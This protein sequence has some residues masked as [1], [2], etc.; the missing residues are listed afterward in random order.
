[1]KNHLTLFLTMVCLLAVALG[2]EFSATTANL[3]DI[4]LAKDK[5]ASNPQTTFESGDEIFAVTA[6]NNTSSKHK[7]KFRLLVVDVQGADPGTVAYKLDKEMEIDGARDFWYTFSV[8]GNGFVPGKYKV[9]FKLMDEKG[10][11]EIQ[12]KTAEFTIKGG[13]SPMPKTDS[14]EP[15]DPDED[16]SDEN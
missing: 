5:S 8:P 13:K 6:L 15:T 10:E 7:V 14:D 12:T 11:K 9:E 1:M 4:K 3:S 16:S 2:C